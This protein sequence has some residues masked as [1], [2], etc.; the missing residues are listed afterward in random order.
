MAVNSQ[1]LDHN[2]IEHATGIHLANCNSITNFSCNS[3]S[4]FDYVLEHCQFH[5][6]E[7]CHLKSAS[8]FDSIQPIFLVDP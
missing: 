7:S 8:S 4:S 2:S 3:N 1:S 5:M 6:Q